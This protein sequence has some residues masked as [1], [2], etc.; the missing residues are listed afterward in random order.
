M[1]TLNKFKLVDVLESDL[2]GVLDGDAHVLIFKNKFS[3]VVRMTLPEFQELA[4]RSR[5]CMLLMD[6]YESPRV[7]RLMVIKS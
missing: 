5:K 7:A 6:A 1:L 2:I 3:D 4:A